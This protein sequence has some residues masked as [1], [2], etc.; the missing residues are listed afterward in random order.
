VTTFG[1]RPIWTA[2]LQGFPFSLQLRN[3]HLLFA[4]CHL[5][6]AG[7]KCSPFIKPL[8]VPWANE[9]TIEA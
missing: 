3:F 5:P 9:R 4:I 7:W 8:L 6:F 1:F 2:F